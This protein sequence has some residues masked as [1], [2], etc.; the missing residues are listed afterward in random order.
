[1]LRAFYLE[2]RAKAPAAD[3]A[4]ITTRQLESLIRLTEA[5]ARADLRTIATQCASAVCGARAWQDCQLIAG[6]H[7]WRRPAP[8]RPNRHGSCSARHGHSWDSW[9]LKLSR[10]YR[11]VAAGTMRKTWST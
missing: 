4:P 3:G 6:V 2:L 1:M 9:K 10:A 8:Q 11:L 7:V 5:R